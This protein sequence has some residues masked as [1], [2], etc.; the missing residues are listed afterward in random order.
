MKRAR[1]RAD[2]IDGVAA[3]HACN[4]IPPSLLAQTSTSGITI[5]INTAGTRISSVA[6]RICK[7]SRPVHEET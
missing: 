6:E 7:A 1:D 4:R 2:R 5:P 3:A